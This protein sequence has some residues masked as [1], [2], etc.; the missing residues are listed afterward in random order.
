MQRLFGTEKKKQSSKN[1]P[2]LALPEVSGQV[3]N[4][5]L[6]YSLEQERE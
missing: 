1:T 2:T 4:V 3:W 5:N 6:S